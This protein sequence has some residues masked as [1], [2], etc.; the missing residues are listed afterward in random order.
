MKRF[1]QSTILPCI[2]VLGMF[3]WGVQITHAFTTFTGDAKWANANPGYI[4][5]D[6]LKEHQVSVTR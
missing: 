6:K 3:F 5:F 4:V 1:V 2:L